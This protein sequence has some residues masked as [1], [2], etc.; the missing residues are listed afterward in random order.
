MRQAHSPP[1]CHASS[2][3]LLLLHSFH[4]FYVA[5]ACLHCVAA[6]L[7]LCAPRR[8]CLK[9]SDEDQSGALDF[10]EFLELMSRR[11]GEEN[12]EMGPDE[13]RDERALG[14]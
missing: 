2:Y 9:E 11:F 4:R 5:P 1:C 14:G 7:L 10:V 13:V 12:P 6:V 8:S 3:G